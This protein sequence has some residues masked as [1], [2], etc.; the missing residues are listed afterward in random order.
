[1]LQFYV[2]DN[3]WKGTLDIHHFRSL[4]DAIRH[5]QFLVLGVDLLDKLGQ[6][7]AVR[8]DFELAVGFIGRDTG[9][10]RP[11]EGVRVELLGG[12]VRHLP[13]RWR[14]TP[15]ESSRFPGCAG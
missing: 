12:G 6:Q 11:V 15:L 9:R 8:P 2:V 3:L 1:M 7:G 5:P 4:P 13:G 10:P 14:E